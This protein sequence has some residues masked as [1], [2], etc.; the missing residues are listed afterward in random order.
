MLFGRLEGELDCGLSLAA[1]ARRVKDVKMPETSAQLFD[2][3][4]THSTSRTAFALV[5]G[6][7]RNI[8][9]SDTPVVSPEAA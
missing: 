3:R 8:V 6:Y 2:M 5:E 1:S 7:T 4:A 9:S